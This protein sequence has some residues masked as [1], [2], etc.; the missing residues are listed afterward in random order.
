LK[1]HFYRF[2]ILESVWL[3]ISPI[4]KD[5]ASFMINSASLFIK[6]RFLKM[7]LAMIAGSSPVISYTR[8][9]AN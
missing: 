7:K 9:T 5:F 1:F 8:D 6:I 3:N 2:V 4:Y